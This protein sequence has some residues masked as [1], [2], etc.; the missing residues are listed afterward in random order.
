[1][2]RKEKAQVRD[3]SKKI[4]EGIRDN[5]G[6]KTHEKVQNIL[7]EDKEE[8]N[9]NHAYEKRSQRHRSNEDRNCQHIRQ[10]WTKICIQVR[11]MKKKRG[12]Q[13]RNEDINKTN[14]TQDVPCE[15]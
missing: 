14:T 5:K 10:N 3:I 9:S 6:S 13:R 8:E 11:A 1:M 7:E 12:G 15:N 4:N 2:E